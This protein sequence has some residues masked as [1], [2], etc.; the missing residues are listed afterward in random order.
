LGKGAAAKP[1]GPDP[2]RHACLMK[3]EGMVSQN[4]AR[5]SIAAAGATT[6]LLNQ[7]YR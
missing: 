6:G 5:V 4:I 3:L 7:Q 1:S 2:F